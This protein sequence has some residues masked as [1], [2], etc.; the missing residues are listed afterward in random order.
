MKSPL[1]NV[2]NSLQ[3]FVEFSDDKLDYLGAFLDM[4]TNYY[5]HTGVQTLARRLVERAY[6][7]I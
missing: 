2:A 7:E 4:S 5:E 3:S 6:A 1:A